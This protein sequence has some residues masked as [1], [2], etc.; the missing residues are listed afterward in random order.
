MYTNKQ[1]QNCSAINILFSVLLGDML[2]SDELRYHGLLFEL[3][4]CF[5]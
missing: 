1:S 2:T 3:S 4:S 5:L